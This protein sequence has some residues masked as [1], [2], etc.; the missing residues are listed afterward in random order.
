MWG[1]AGG[2]PAMGGAKRPAARKAKDTTSHRWMAHRRCGRPPGQS[3][4][5]GRTTKKALPTIYVNNVM[6]SLPILPSHS[7]QC[8]RWLLLGD[9]A[10]V[11][12][13]EGIHNLS[14]PGMAAGEPERPPPP[15]RPTLAARADEVLSRIF[16]V[17][18]R[19]SPVLRMINPE[20]AFTPS[21]AVGMAG[22]AVRPTSTGEPFC[23]GT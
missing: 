8:P 23:G 2:S 16:R 10:G 15:G 7:L 21:R 17:D 1:G 12:A 19:R 18:M 6:A 14:S 9:V 13:S 11:G 5:N 20:L 4:R 22:T 3:H